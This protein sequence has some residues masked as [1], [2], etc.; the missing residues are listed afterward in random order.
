MI[1]S[2]NNSFSFG[3]A[4][5]RVIDLKS[6]ERRNKV[7]LRRITISRVRG[8]SAA[9]STRAQISVANSLMMFAVWKGQKQLLVEYKVTSSTLTA[10]GQLA[11]QLH[12]NLIE[13]LGGGV[14]HFAHKLGKCES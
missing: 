12:F 7:K 6:R 13:L 11:Q 3:F 10:F 14:K 1:E 4:S 9:A 8:Q 2:S 5:A